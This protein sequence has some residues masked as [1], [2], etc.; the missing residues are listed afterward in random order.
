MGD[1]KPTDN[2]RLAK[3]QSFTALM[4][5]LRRAGFR[6]DFVSKALLPDWW[7]DRCSEDSD[8]IRELE[9][10]VARFLNVTLASVKDSSA[11]LGAPGYAGAQ[12][13]RVRDL[14]RDQL[15]P[16]IHG[17][18]RIASAAV[19]NLREGRAPV[20]V[21]PTD[22]AEWRSSLQ[23]SSPALTL[24]DITVDLW[25][26]GIP[27]VPLET[28]PAPSFQGMA[29]IVEDRPVVLLGYKHDEPSRAAFIIAHE[30]EHILAGDC[31]VN[32]P[33]VDEEDE[34]SDES[35]IEV[36]ADAYAKKVLVGDVPLP[37]LQ[38]VNFKELAQKASEFERSTGADASSVAF[39]WARQTG[40]YATAT[41][42]VKALY[43]ASGA[44]KQLQRIFEERVDVAGAPETDRDLLRCVIDTK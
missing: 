25:N 18:I 42:A 15:A 20:R 30:T 35:D 21:P 14:S 31:S 19:R 7:D 36:R 12:L 6:G 44:R 28:L 43:R 23:R 32:Q 38:F 26:R 9:I 29:C 40:D 16:A 17:A 33:V 22:P 39:A 24:E 4:K 5:R 37:V 10:R 34:I 3:G 2:T 1:R 13:R 41:M 11:P 8:L 27:V